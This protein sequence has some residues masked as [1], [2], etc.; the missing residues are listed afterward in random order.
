MDLLQAEANTLFDMITAAE[1]IVVLFDEFDEIVRERESENSEM[2]SRLL[3]TAMLPKLSQIYDRRRVVFIL[4][5]NHLEQFDF[6]ISRLG[7]F[8]RI[9]QVMPPTTAAKLAN[10]DAER[11][12]LEAI[13]TN[14]GDLAKDMEVL[15]YKEFEEMVPELLEAQTSQR[16][17]Q[18]VEDFA[19]KSV[20]RQKPIGSDQTWEE[21]SIQQRGR[22][23]F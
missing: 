10:W 7:R 13:G 1:R 12:H 23:R 9:F 14:L 11:R 18:I 16:A 19:K 2:I 5:T 22:N 15:I 20:L 3:T 21:K 4:A 8:D 17:A 6:A